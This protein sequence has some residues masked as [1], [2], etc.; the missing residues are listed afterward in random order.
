M[1]NDVFL[2]E[3]EAELE[4][5]LSSGAGEAMARRRAAALTYVGPVALSGYTAAPNVPGLYNIFRGGVLVYTGET[6]H[7]RTR[8]SQ[9]QL[10]LTHLQIPTAPYT[11]NYALMPRSSRRSRRSAERRV[12]DANRPLLPQ[13]REME[14]GGDPLTAAGVD[15]A[16]SLNSQYSSSL[17]WGEYAGRIA[18][19]LGFSGAMPAPPGFA[20]A[21][22]RWQQG[23]TGLTVDGVIG[24]KTLP[25]MRAA[26]GLVPSIDLPRAIRLNRQ[27]GLSLGWHAYRQ[28][29][30][31]WLLGLEEHPPETDFAER[32]AIWQQGQQGLE[33]D[34]IIGPQTLP[35]MKAALGP[36]LDAGGTPPSPPGVITAQAPTGRLRRAMEAESTSESEFFVVEQRV[37]GRP[38]IPRGHERLTEDAALPLFPAGS[39]E[40]R[41]LLVG[42]VRVDELAR[43]FIPGD[44][45][46]HCLRQELCQE[47]GPALRDARSHLEG[48]HLIAISHIPTAFE[49]AGEA[50]HLIQDSYS[51]AHTERTLR[52]AGPPHPIVVIR[53]FGS[54]GCTHPLEHRVFPPPDP[55]DFITLRG[56]G[57]TDFARA[58]VAASRE[59]LRMLLRHRAGVPLPIVRTDLTAFMDRHLVLSGSVVPTRTFYPKCPGS[60]LPPYRC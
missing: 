39:P 37:L 54:M 38:I 18:R 24:P 10:C 19:L 52:A 6:Q 26:L 23:Q 21:V 46:R 30:A 9:H 40:L 32:T 49:M 59:Y 58:G 4:A 33:V 53:F 22:A 3:S 41:A 28:S 47:Q 14:S 17:G 1:R 50:L 2:G 11:F 12:I 43:A 56:G 34:G 15:R 13:Q 55:R 7:L 8:L 20:Q 45:R 35:R 27:Y 42:V 5:L 31:H 60:T 51:N 29:L 16:V 36:I 48:L 57:L 25:R 44:Q